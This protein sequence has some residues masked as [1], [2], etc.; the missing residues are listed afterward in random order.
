MQGGDLRAVGRV[1]R[2]PPYLDSSTPGWL[3]LTAAILRGA[4]KLSGAL[5]RGRAELF[6]GQ[7]PEARAVA[8]GVCRRCPARRDCVDFAR[9]TASWRERPV[10]VI[11]GRFRG[12]KE[13]VLA[14]R[15]RG[16]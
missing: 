8:A 6:D 7:T 1:T 15:R 11:G 10:G 9:R 5:C 2:P 13:S 4:P 14:R 3:L 12:Q 16:D